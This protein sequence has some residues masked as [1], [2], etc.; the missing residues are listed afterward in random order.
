MH[1]MKRVDRAW[2][3]IVLLVGLEGLFGSPRAAAADVR[4]PNIVLMLGDDLGYGDLGAYGQSRIAT[5]NLDRLAAAGMRFT[6][7]Y[8]GSTVCAPSRCCLMTGR[9]TG[10]ARVRG[11]GLVPLR[12]EDVTVAEVLKGA[13]YAT[14]L[15]GKWGLG[16]AET[17]GYPTR[18]GFDEFFGY[19]NQ[20]H[21]HNYYPDFLWKGEDRFPLAG[22]VEGPRKGIAAAR[23]STPPT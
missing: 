21:A 4:K 3:G 23:P 8:A 1:A 18:Q 13:G 11:N 15:F 5:P 17:T 2:V 10:H 19:V 6:Q 16:E 12:P 20:V 7:C 9:N 22:N 14:G